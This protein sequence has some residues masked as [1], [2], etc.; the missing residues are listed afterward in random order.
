MSLFDNETHAKRLQILKDVVPSASKIAF[1]NP[2]RLGRMLVGKRCNEC[3]N[4]SAD[5]CNCR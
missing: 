4:K 2:R 3:F 5:D 1:L